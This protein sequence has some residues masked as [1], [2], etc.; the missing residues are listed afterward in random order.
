MASCEIHLDKNGLEWLRKYLQRMIKSHANKWSKDTNICR[1][2]H[3]K[4]VMLNKWNRFFKKYDIT[5]PQLKK[6]NLIGM[7]TSK[8]KTSY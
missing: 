7:I 3:I 5:K 1:Y 4:I 2:L 6:K 8:F